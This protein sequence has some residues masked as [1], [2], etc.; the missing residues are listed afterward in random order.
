MRLISNHLTKFYFLIIC[1]CTYNN[2]QVRSQL[3]NSNSWVNYEVHENDDTTY[4]MAIAE[5]NG[6]SLELILANTIIRMGPPV[7]GIYNNIRLTLYYEDEPHSHFNEKIEY[8]GFIDVGFNIFD[9]EGQIA[10]ISKYIVT[11]RIRKGGLCTWYEVSYQ[12][13]GDSWKNEGSKI[14]EA[15]KRGSYTNVLIGDY[16]YKFSL[17]GFT[18]CFNLISHN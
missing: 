6:R 4:Y 15:M 12:T 8:A 11:M 9:E 17:S 18:K 14:I 7:K 16:V 10:N 3:H 13:E 1:I 2:M 5:I